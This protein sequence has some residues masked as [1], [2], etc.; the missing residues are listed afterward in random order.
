MMKFDPTVNLGHVLTA[1]AMLATGFIAY[2]TLAQ[3][4]TVQEQIANERAAQTKD[5]LVE[6]KSD[7]KELR[8][9]VRRSLA[10]G[11]R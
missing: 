6:I 9:E 3:R 7:V 5:T 4:V 8:Q 1:S 2:G 10:S 11:G